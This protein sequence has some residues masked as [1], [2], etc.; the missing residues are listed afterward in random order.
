MTQLHDSRPFQLGNGTVGRQ[1]FYFPGEN[2]QFWQLD[3]KN[4]EKRSEYLL[5]VFYNYVWYFFDTIIGLLIANPD[6]PGP[7]LDCPGLK[8]FFV[9]V[10]LILGRF[11]ST[12]W[13]QTIPAGKWYSWAPGIRFSNRKCS[14]LT[15][16][17]E[18]WGKTKWVI[19]YFTMFSYFFLFLL[20][21]ARL[22]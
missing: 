18:K 1:E 9:L 7:G 2:D 3:V 15:V 16:R 13:F 17:F 4:E 19:F 20:G 14:I 11:D 12:S 10:F 22:C 8:G 21:F 6:C 5:F